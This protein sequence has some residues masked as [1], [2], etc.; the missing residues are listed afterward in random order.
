MQGATI[1]P[2]ATAKLLGVAWVRELRWKEHVQQ[3]VKQATKTTSPLQDFGISAPAS[4]I[5]VAARLRKKMDFRPRIIVGQDEEVKEV[6][7]RL[8]EMIYWVSSSGP[9]MIYRE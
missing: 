3:A 1:K 7:G 4:A 6:D 9:L 8:P 2:S 5:A